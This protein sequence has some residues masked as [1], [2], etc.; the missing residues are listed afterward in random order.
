GSISIS[1]IDNGP[2]PAVS[3]NLTTAC[4]ELVHYFPTVMIVR[5][6]SENSDFNDDGGAF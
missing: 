6:L 5:V 2:F 4:G 3:E 1:G